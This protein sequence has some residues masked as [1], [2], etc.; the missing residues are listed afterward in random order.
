MG[1]LHRQ[2]LGFANVEIAFFFGLPFGIAGKVSRLSLHGYHND[3]M[4][5]LANEEE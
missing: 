1:E 5:S 4:H 2:G 3:T